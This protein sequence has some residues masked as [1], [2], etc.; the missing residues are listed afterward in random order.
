M[1][2]GTRPCS[3]CTRPELEGYPHNHDRPMRSSWDPMPPR[4]ERLYCGV[5]DVNAYWTEPG[6]RPDCCL[7]HLVAAEWRAELPERLHPVSEGSPTRLE[8]I[9]VEPRNLAGPMIDVPDRGRL[10]GWPWAAAAARRLG[11]VTMFEGEQTLDAGDYRIFPWAY[12]LERRLDGHC[13]RRHAG[14]LER[15]PEHAGRPICGPLLRAIIARGIPPEQVAARARIPPE[16]LA[17]VLED[18][19]RWVWRRVSEALNEIEARPQK[20]AG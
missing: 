11:G 7:V 15:W 20:A 14:Q 9:P 5:L 12:V 17:A 8:P 16:R 10:G 6:W 4:P 3:V 18:S 2:P 13:R 1:T 19:L